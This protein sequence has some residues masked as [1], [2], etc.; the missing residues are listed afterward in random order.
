MSAS[1]RWTAAPVDVFPKGYR[2]YAMQLQEA[3]TQLAL[4][5]APQIQAW[6]H[7]N[8][9]WQDRTGNARAALFAEVQTLI[10]GI[11]LAIGHGVDY[12]TYLEYA[13]AGAYSIIGPALDTWSLELW[14][15]IRSLLS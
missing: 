14:N 12:G 9:P 13:H 15:A 7:A 11:V 1:F 10:N 5:Y 6:M 2:Q 3:L 4:L 8:A